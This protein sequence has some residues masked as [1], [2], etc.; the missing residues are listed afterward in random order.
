[1]RR[2]KRNY[3]LDTPKGRVQHAFDHNGSEVA[4]RLADELG[5][6]AK[7]TRWQKE[8]AETTSPAPAVSARVRIAGK[9]YQPARGDRVARQ[10]DK[11][12]EPGTVAEAGLEQS[13]VRWDRLPGAQPQAESNRSLIR[14]EST[15]T[16]VT[17]RST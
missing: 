3:R 17:R 15:R 10:S 12:Q 5:V 1:M 4:R 13:M 16:R 14:I 11:D 6:S 8:W 7:F 9:D 2:I